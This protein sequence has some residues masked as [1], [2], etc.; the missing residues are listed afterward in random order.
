M[1]L[2][3]ALRNA[4]RLGG[5]PYYTGDIDGVLGG[6][7]AQAIRLYRKDH[8][9]SE[10]AVVDA[11]LLRLLNLNQEQSKVN[12][13]NN[14][15][16]SLVASTA[17]KYIIAMIATFIASKL[18]LEQGSVEGILVQLIG[19]AAGL[20]GAWEASRSKVV[21]NGT[22][23]TLDKMTTANQQK[24]AEAAATVK[25]EVATK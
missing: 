1:L 20:W 13:S 17:G 8:G 6:K 2:Q 7:S 3:Q 23:V 16:S 10:A 24:V 9:L 14:W 4:K 15:L 22:K 25:P 18:G 5:S 12:T 21:V 11:K 19:V